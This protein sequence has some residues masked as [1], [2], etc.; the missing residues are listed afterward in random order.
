MSPKWTPKC[1]HK[2]WGWGAEEDGQCSGEEGGQ[3]Q[4]LGRHVE[5][6]LGLGFFS[7]HEEVEEGLWDQSVNIIYDGVFSNLP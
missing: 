2:S 1:T 4:V 3:K 7:K 6:D 5:M